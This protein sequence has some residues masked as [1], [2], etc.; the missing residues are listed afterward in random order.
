MP[1]IQHLE[2]TDKVDRKIKAIP[3]GGRCLRRALVTGEP[4]LKMQRAWHG[5]V[6]W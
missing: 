5:P 4:I 1:V 3:D 6:H 2:D